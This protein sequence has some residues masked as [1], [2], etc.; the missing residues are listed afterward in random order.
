[1]PRYEDETQEIPS[2]NIGTLVVHDTFGRGR[3]V[4]LDGRGE[5]MRAIVDFEVVGRKQLML[6]FAHLRLL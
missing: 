4:G 2:V 3:I 5:R 6:K 1:M